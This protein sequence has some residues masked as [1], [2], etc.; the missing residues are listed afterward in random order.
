[1]AMLDLSLEHPEIVDAGAKDWNETS[2]G[3]SKGRQKEMMVW[4]DQARPA[5]GQKVQH[6]LLRSA[7]EPC[8][9]YPALVCCRVQGLE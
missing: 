4:K 9:V 7:W 3:P 1:M 2:L 5:E 8:N 6:R